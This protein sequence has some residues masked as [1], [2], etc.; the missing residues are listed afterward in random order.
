MA[1]ITI[2]QPQEDAIKKIKGD[3]EKAIDKLHRLQRFAE[4][5]PQFLPGIDI[6]RFKKLV[7]VIRL[8]YVPYVPIGV[9]T[10]FAA[11]GLRTVV[12]L[13]ELERWLSQPLSD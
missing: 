5:T 8:P 10:K 1:E 6:S 4:T 13:S 7:Y 9:A 11:P 12:S 2:R 3:V